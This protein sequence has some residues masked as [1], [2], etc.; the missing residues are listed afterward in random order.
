[1][2]RN[3]CYPLSMEGSLKMKEIT[4][5]HSESYPSGELKHGPLALID[6]NFHTIISC[7]NN[8]V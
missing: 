1:M 5:I 7:L 6:E 4:Y 3:L 2:G 8:D